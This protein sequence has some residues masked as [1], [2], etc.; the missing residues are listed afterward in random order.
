MDALLTVK[1]D[2]VDLHPAIAARIR[3]QPDLLPSRFPAGHLNERA[4]EFVLRTHPIQVTPR[5]EPAEP[6]SSDSATLTG[7][8]GKPG[9][10]RSKGPYYCV[11]GL[12]TFQIAKPRLAPDSIVP[13]LLIQPP[14]DPA[15]VAWLDLFLGAIVCGIQGTGSARQIGRLW[16]A[17]PKPSREQ[18]FPDLKS[19][20]ALAQELGVSEKSILG[21]GTKKRTAD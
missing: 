1:L 12:R 14:A 5:A 20:T 16:D 10:Q 9:R 17:I 2:Q 7:A 8:R 15:A 6:Q 11:G 19:R 21:R 13:V 3:E 18:L 4:L